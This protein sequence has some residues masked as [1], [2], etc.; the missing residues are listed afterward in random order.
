VKYTFLADAQDLEMPNDT[1]KIQGGFDAAFSNAALHWC[2]RDPSGVL[3]SVRK[4]LKP[5]GRFIVEMGGFM[6]CIGKVVPSVQKI[7]R[8]SAYYRCKVCFARHYKIKRPQ[9]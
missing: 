8:L 2:K 9:S 1:P 7:R 4:V 5:G 6:N 3:T